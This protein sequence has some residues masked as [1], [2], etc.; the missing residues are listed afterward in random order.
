MK[1]KSPLVSFLNIEL[2]NIDEGRLEKVWK[3]EYRDENNLEDLQERRKMQV[4]M[5]GTIEPPKLTCARSVMDP[6]A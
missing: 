2:Q 5:C 1:A 6:N 4:L 3:A